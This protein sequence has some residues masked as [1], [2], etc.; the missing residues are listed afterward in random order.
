MLP[1]RSEVFGGMISCQHALV[2]CLACSLID[3]LL[4]LRTYKDLIS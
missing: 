3:Y 4:Q 2:S 1:K